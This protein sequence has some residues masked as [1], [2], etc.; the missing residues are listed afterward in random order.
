MANK[1]F[2]LPQTKGTFQVRGIVSGVEKDNFYTEKKTKTGKEMR[3]INFGVEYEDKKTIYPSLNGMPRDK[4]YFSKKD[5]ETGKIITKAVDWKNR[6]KSDT[7]GYRLIGVNLG[8][9]KTTDEKGKEINDKKT[10]P[11][12]DACKYMSEK[13]ADDMSVFVKGNLEFGSYTNKDGEVSRTTK[14]VPTQVSLCQKDVDFE[15]EDYAP[16]HDFTQTIVFV[17]IDQ[18][19][20]NDKPTGRFVVDAK[21]V[22]YNSIESAE[23]IIEDAKLAKQMRSGLKPYNSIQVHGHINVVNNVEDVNDEE[24]DDCW[25]ESNDMDKRVFAPTH[26]E[27]IITGAKPSTIDKETYTEKAIDEAIKKV[28]ASKKAE[29]DFTGKA[30]STSNA[31]DDWGDD[32]SD[33]ED[34][35]W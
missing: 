13:M 22:N 20:E 16:A 31:D 28:N 5:D 27:L 18:E 14:F 10:M 23:F 30:E 9:E 15:A 8:I 21:I 12:F 26:R 35:P 29:Q 6:L 34:E 24:D 19:R 32:T 3:M 25:G 17:G 2:E 1:L 7:E 4:V 33:D 11:E